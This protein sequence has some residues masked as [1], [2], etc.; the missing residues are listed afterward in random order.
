MGAC[1]AIYVG[2]LLLSLVLFLSQESEMLKEVWQ[3]QDKLQTQLLTHANEV[4]QQISN[5]CMILTRDSSM[6]SEMPITCAFQVLCKMSPVAR[7]DLKLCKEGD[8]VIV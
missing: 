8:S 6:L 5:S 2:L 3:K 1:S 4:S 7:T